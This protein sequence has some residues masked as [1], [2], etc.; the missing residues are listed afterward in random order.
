MLTTYSQSVQKKKM[1]VAREKGG[2][3]GERRE[4]GRWRERIN[5][6]KC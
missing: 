2:K 5:L 6:E 1:Y 3:N 4:R